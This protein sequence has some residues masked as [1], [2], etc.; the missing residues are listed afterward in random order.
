MEAIK[1]DSCGGE[2]HAKTKMEFEYHLHIRAPAGESAAGFSLP[3]DDGGG[4]D[5]LRQNNGREL[6]SGGTRENR[7]SAGRPC[8]R[9]FR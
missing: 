8:Q 3:T 4:A 1:Q 9:V 6:V 5:G 7:A 2:H